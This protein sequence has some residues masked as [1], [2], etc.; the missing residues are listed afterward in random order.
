MKVEGQVR[1]DL[2]DLA[3]RR[4]RTVY[5]GLSSNSDVI[6]SDLS[7]LAPGVYVYSLSTESG[8]Y[9]HKVVKR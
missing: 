8:Q 2:M 5:E 7:D 4:I 1:I 3:G 9:N 6:E